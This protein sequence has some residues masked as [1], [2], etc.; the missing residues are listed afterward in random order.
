M[1]ALRLPESVTVSGREY[2]IR[3]DFRTVIEILVAL[4]D[5]E[6]DQQGKAEVVLKCFYPDYEE[7]RKEDAEAAL[8]AAAVFI[9]GGEELPES[10]RRHR[11][12]DWEQDF[13]RIAAPVSRILGRD[14]R[15][16]E[17]LHWWTFLA[18]YY[19]IGDCLF[20]QIVRIR[21]LRAKGKKLDKADREWYR[22][23][24][25]L[26]NFR[27][28]YTEAEDAALNTWLAQAGDKE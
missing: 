8:K 22:D 5:P 9:D 18:A 12:M 28:K 20:A 1:I 11:L 19:E 21:N 23:N 6:L 15:T 10:A 26:V 7:I 17:N 24:A 13:P 4:A 25:A 27:Q 14:V 16:V 3:S 2:A